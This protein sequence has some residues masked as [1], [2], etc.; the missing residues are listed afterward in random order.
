MSVNSSLNNFCR[1]GRP[2]SEA[3]PHILPVNGSVNVG[4]VSG[5]ITSLA[6]DVSRRVDVHNSLASLWAMQKSYVT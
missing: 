1:M 4:T 3:Q 2:Y 6:M 5:W